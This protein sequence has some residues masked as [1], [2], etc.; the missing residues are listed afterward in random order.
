[1]PSK[2]QLS[3]KYLEYRCET[4]PKL[5]TEH[6]C[7]Y[8]KYFHANYEAD[9]TQKMRPGKIGQK[10]CRKDARYYIS[11]V[12]DIAK[13]S[14]HIYEEYVTFYTHLYLL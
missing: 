6:T 10:R 4:E 9:L 2:L 12:E 7:I 3:I 14:S 11:C 5:F 8:G 1:M 13:T